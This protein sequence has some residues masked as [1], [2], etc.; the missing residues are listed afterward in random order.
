MEIDLAH[1]S[2]DLPALARQLRSQVCIIGG[3]IAGLTIAQALSS[4]E[5]PTV[6]VLEAG[7]HGITGGSAVDPF[8]ARLT[9]RPHRGTREGRVRALG[10]SSLVW[11]GQLLPLSQDVSWPLPKAALRHQPEP[12][13]SDAIRTLTSHRLGVPQL[14]GS[15]V[16]LTAR[17]SRFLPFRQ[18]NYAKTLGRQLRR[19]AGTRIV[20][21]AQ[22]IGLVL[23][24]AGDRVECASVRTPDGRTFPLEADHFVLAAGTVETC[25]LLLA[26][27]IGKDYGQVG[28]NFHDHLTLPAAEFRGE[29][30]ARVLAELRPWV[31]RTNGNGRALHSLKLEASPLLREQLGIHPAMAHITME[32]PEDSG[33]GK[34]RELFRARQQGSPRGSLAA[35]LRA[36]PRA[37]GEG[38]RLAWSALVHRRRYVSGRARVFL[39]LNIAQDAPSASRVLLSDTVAGDG[40][41][42][43]VVDW[44]ITPAELR[45]FRCFAAHLRETLSKAGLRDDV[46]WHPALFAEG[47]QADEQLLAVLDDAR[48]AMGGACLG[49]DPQTSVVDPELRVHGISDLSVASPAVF[50]DGS[51][52]LPTATLIALCQRLAQRL[53]RELG[54]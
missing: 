32:E 25:R 8:A 24:S 52:Q 53:G 29:A 18:R 4:S 13:P 43:A 14:L 34:L 42:Q 7:A 51:A 37:I 33:I 26:S 19:A 17:L 28:R 22:C 40:L 47:S 3:G 38:V 9:G 20:L 11:G 27:G 36:L 41:P 6:T 54:A 21:G 2:S 50:P 49:N 44:Q 30:R 1:A 48:H 5:T 45:S 39:Q 35:G 10:G 15:L 16:G 31:F 23:S 46:A 12:E